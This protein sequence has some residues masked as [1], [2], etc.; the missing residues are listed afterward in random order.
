MATTIGQSALSRPDSVAKRAFTGLASTS[1]EWYDFFL[2]GTAAALVFPKVFFPQTLPPFV[3]LIA[4][5]STFT[6]GFI[7][8]PIGAVIFGHFGDRAGRKAA[9][10]AALLMMG[11]GTTLI[12]CL[13]PYSTV[14]AVAPLLLVV[15]R[16]V[17][18][19]AIGG[20]WG[21]AMLLVTE[22]APPGKRGFHGSFAQ[23]GVPVGVV[24]ANLALLVAGATTDADDFMSWGWRI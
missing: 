20:Q 12:G 21:G 9:L 16:F 14:G 17:Q 10:V 2:Y 23:A 8:R 7:A 6:V 24:L 11:G 3:A 15:F 4:S 1:V 13:P 22:S 19:L 18:G 5:F